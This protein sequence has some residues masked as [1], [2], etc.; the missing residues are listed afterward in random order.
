MDKECESREKGTRHGVQGRVP[1]RRARGDDVEQANAGSCREERC[2]PGRGL[3]HAEALWQEGRKTGE[4]EGPQGWS[5]ETKREHDK[6][7]RA[8]VGSGTPETMYFPIHFSEKS[9]TQRVCSSGFPAL[10]ICK[11]GKQ[12]YL[13]LGCPGDY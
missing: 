9:V 10:I 13:L 5:T 8:R 11:M 2:Q 12:F 1:Q 4:K 3:A 6:V 7:S